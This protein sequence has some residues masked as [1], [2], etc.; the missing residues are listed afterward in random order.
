MI[1]I[2]KNNSPCA[3][4]HP[5]NMDSSLNAINFFRPKAL[6]RA[7]H[8]I[9]SSKKVLC[10]F[11]L[12]L[13][14]SFLPV[15]SP[16]FAATEAKNIKQNEVDKNFIYKL[17]DKIKNTLGTKGH[18]RTFD[19]IYLKDIEQSHPVNNM[20]YGELLFYYYQN[21]PLKS[22]IYLM[23]SDDRNRFQQHSD[24]AETLRGSLYLSMG[25]TEHAKYYFN[26][27]IE[28]SLSPVT[29]N[30]AWIALAELAYRQNNYQQTKYILSNK[31]EELNDSDYSV[32][33]MN[34]V[35]EYLG[36]IYLRED[37][38]Q[39]AINEFEL[40]Y[41]DPL[42][43]RYALYN[44][45][46]AHFHTNQVDTATFYL[47]FLLD[48]PT[49]NTED[50]A[51]RDKAAS[52]LGQFYLFENDHFLSRQSYRE[53]R[54]SSAFANEALLGLGWMNLKGAN[55]TQALSAWLELI[56]RDQSQKSVQEAFLLTARAYE[57]LNA[58]QD[59]L[60]AYITAS[61]TYENQIDN[62]I[63][64]HDFVNQD[65]WLNHLKL[66]SSDP[67]EFS[68]IYSYISTPFIPMDGTEASYLY[69][70]YSTNSFNTK[71]Q[72]F[73]QLQ[74]IEAYLHDLKA[75][76]PVYNTMM[77][78]QSL[79]NGLLEDTLNR[80]LDSINL[81]EFSNR[82]EAISK[83]TSHT[84]NEDLL[85]IATKEEQNTLDTLNS[86]KKKLS[87]LPKTKDFDGIKSRFRIVHGTFLWN[88]KHDSYRRSY[89][90]KKQLK[91][92]QDEIIKL[93]SLLK[94]LQQTDINE[95]TKL[96]KHNNHIKA[97][98]LEI[99][100]LILRIQKLKTDQHSELQNLASSVL[101]QRL[102]HTSNLLARTQIAIARLQDKAAS[103]GRNSQ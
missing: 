94:T 25:M 46:L 51:I 42:K 85:F 19:N 102:T 74:H 78:N 81:S 62:I 43:Q 66:L 72:Q 54:L 91:L 71:F 39:N 12:V 93:E 2:R 7:W 40:I 4:G 61:N 59:A 80:T 21:K 35:H 30:K 26:K 60:G 45:A 63:K 1:K 82:L 50:D 55:P 76:L 92:T 100:H 16:S 32:N 67:S 90:L 34:L 20:A 13:I 15:L 17:F 29:R 3:F 98:E 79:K 36:L 57:E 58:Y 44:L 69:Q 23:T 64:A 68:S 88:M 22:L 38:Y 99:D 101:N 11:L 73:W 56:G 52:A 24:H 75:N 14:L 28:T 5:Y 84:I 6:I 37:S 41:N 27:T 97:I 53:V 96:S 48:L 10:Q 9:P 103:E 33:Q 49:Y 87:K 77:E 18:E 70:I 86:L 47:Q 65:E 83:Q 95:L 8:T 31:I 89:S